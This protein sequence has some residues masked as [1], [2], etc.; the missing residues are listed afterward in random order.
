MSRTFGLRCQ[1]GSQEQLVF[2]DPPR[3]TPKA[4]TF[5]GYLSLSLQI[6][7][8]CANTSRSVP[9]N[10]AFAAYTI[11]SQSFFVDWRSSSSVASASRPFRAIIDTESCAKTAVAFQDDQVHLTPGPPRNWQVST[12]ETTDLLYLNS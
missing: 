8:F 2:K 5:N 10:P 9:G 7:S 3:A 12:R 4:L 6:L 1:D 11:R